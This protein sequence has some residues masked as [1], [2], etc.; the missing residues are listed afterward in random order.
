MYFHKKQKMNA[1]TKIGINN[2]ATLNTETIRSYMFKNGLKLYKKKT[3]QL[4]ETKIHKKKQLP[5]S[6]KFDEVKL[7]SANHFYFL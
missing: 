1:R 3:V 2:I 6:E 4:F 7:H 5:I